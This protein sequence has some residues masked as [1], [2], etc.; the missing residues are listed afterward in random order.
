[1]HGNPNQQWYASKFCHWLRFTHKTLQHK[2]VIYSFY[3]NV[4]EGHQNI[5]FYFEAAKPDK[6]GSQYF[7]F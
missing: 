5:L 2:K 6:G 7:V 3:F 1:M 4:A